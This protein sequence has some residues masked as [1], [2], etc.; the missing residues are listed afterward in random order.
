VPSSVPTSR[1]PADERT[2]AI[3]VNG[4]PDDIRLIHELV[5]KIDI[6]LPQVR[7]EVIIADVT[8]D[9]TDTTGIDALAS[10]LPI[11]NLL[12]STSAAPRLPSPAPAQPARLPRMPRW[13]P[14]ADCSA[15]V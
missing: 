7:I 2:N 10:R 4:T 9:D 3:V 1:S 5:D 15:T 8:L 12:A 14:A 11:T 6:I 13:R